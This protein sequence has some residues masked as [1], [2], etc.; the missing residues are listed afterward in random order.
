MHKLFVYGT[1]RRGESQAQLLREATFLGR[2]FTEPKFTLCD[3][4]E[5]PAAIAWG[6][7]QICGEVYEVSD[8]QLRAI[9]AYEEYP[10]IF[11]RRQIRTTFGDA[12]IYLMRAPPALTCVIGHGDWCRRDELELD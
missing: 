4:D 10:E 2:T 9:D 3:L 1:L 12:W 8:E 6:S 5:Y 7:T 11:T